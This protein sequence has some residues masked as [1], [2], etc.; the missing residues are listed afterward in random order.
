MTPALAERLKHS[1]SPFDGIT[2]AVENISLTDLRQHLALA[3]AELHREFNSLELEQNDDWH[4]HDGYTK[5]GTTASWS[6]VLG[7]TESEESLMTGWYSEDYVHRGV[8]PRDFQW[9]VRFCLDEELWPDR[10]GSRNVEELNL[11]WDISGQPEL[12][13]RIFN[14]IQHVGTYDHVIEAS[15][16]W[17]EKSGYT[18]DEF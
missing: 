13:Q 8:H 17:F 9:Y 15:M 12:V 5:A 16:S 11:C 4:W 2:L 18:M 6:E 1:Q 7:W 10:S 14:L 3:A